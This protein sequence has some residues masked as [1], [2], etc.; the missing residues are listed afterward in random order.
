MVSIPFVIAH[1][2]LGTDDPQMVHVFAAVGAESRD[3][4]SGGTF[5]RG[6]MTSGIGA[7]HGLRPLGARTIHVVRDLTE[8]SALANGFID[9]G[10]GASAKATQRET[11]RTDRVVHGTSTATAGRFGAHHFVAD[12]A[13]AANARA[14]EPCEVKEL[15]GLHMKA[16]GNGV[17]RTDGVGRRPATVSAAEILD[18]VLAGDEDRA[19][20][21]VA[22]TVV[23]AILRMERR[24]G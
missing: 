12:A 3:Y 13:I 22:I 4:E 24:R 15:A 17:G 2:H 9:R 19:V 6:G 1:A 5:R 20:I 16:D 21:T 14:I 8:W 11:I 23:V 10:A 7:G 18:Y